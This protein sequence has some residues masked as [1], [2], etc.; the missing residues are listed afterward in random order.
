MSCN[1]AEVWTL[2]EALRLIVSNWQ[3]EEIELLIRGDSQ[4]ALSQVERG[5]G[6]RKPRNFSKASPEFYNACMELYSLVR[7]FHSVATE[8]R[9]RK[10]SVKLFGH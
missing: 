2:I 3:P 6:Q 4:N 7:R 10:H 1:A 9:P 5:T 8:W